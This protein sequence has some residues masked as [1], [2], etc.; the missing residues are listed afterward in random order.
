MVACCAGGNLVRG[1]DLDKEAAAPSAPVEE[2][3]RQ[4]A[5]EG[6]AAPSPGIVSSGDVGL[7]PKASVA[8]LLASEKTAILVVDFQHDFMEG[9]NL[10]VPGANYEDYKTAVVDFVTACRNA[11]RKLCLA[12][13]Q[14]WHPEDHWS[15]AISH[16]DKPAPFSQKKLVRDKDDGTTVETDQTMW[17]VHCVQGSKGAEFVMEVKEGEFIQQKGTKTKWDS[18]SAFEDDGGHETGLTA[19]LKEKGVENVLCLGLATD[20]C[21]FFSATDSVKSGFNTYVIPELCRGIAPDFDFKK[22]TDA[23]CA[24]VPLSDAMTALSGEAAKMA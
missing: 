17:P 13:S 15:F 5:A 16:E 8:E 3:P 12:W 18:Y 6:E 21:V 20:F 14:D 9:G 23:G 4:A 7:L 2:T 19:Y 22:Y 11:K 10:A 1:R 24:K